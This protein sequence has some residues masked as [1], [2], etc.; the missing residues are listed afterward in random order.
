MRVYLYTQTHLTAL[1]LGLPRWAGIRKVKPIWI[2]LIQETV[3]GS[4]ISWAICKSAPS[5]RQITM[6]AP[7]TQFFTGRML[8]LP[9]NQ[10]HQST[11]GNGFTCIMAVKWVVGWWIH[12]HHHYRHFS[13]GLNSENY[14][15]DHCSI[16]GQFDTSQLIVE[17]WLWV[18]VVVVVVVVVVTIVVMVST[19]LT[20]SRW[21]FIAGQFAGPERACSPY[22]WTGGRSWLPGTTSQRG[23]GRW[24]AGSPHTGHSHLQTQSAVQVITHWTGDYMRWCNG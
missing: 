15:K 19:L 5:S 16:A 18:A 3:S 4:G 13:S 10:Q 2:L 1:C 12:Y 7:H 14:C 21:S 23:R 8:F 22:S 20:A 17:L 24:T 9:L 11:D 6:P